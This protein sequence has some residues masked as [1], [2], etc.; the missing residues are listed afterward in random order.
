ML[1]ALYAAYPESPAL[2]LAQTIQEAVCQMR[3]EHP[4]LEFALAIFRRHFQLPPSSTLGIFALGRIIGWIGHAI[5]QY[6]AKQ[7]IQPRI[8]YTGP[9]P[10]R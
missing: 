9:A 3:G 7:T 4:K 2:I 1:G 6:D 8:R 5:K 10:Q